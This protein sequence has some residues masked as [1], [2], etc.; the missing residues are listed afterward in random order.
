MKCSIGDVVTFK[1]G[2]NEIEK[3]EVQFIQKGRIG[4]IL[5]INSF[6]RWAYKVTEKRIVSL[7]PQG[8]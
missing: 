5:Y 2:P 7:V 3:G 1:A 6:N 4:D 8:T